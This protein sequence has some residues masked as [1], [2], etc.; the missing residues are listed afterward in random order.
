MK[1]K[2]T[3]ISLS[4]IATILAICTFNNVAAAPVNKQ[5]TNV[6][7]GYAAD[8]RGNQQTYLVAYLRNNRTAVTMAVNQSTYLYGVL[9]AGTPPTSANDTSHGIPNATINVQ[10]M[11]SDGKTWITVY[12]EKTLPDTGQTGYNYSGR[13]IMTLTPVVAGVYTYRVTYDGDSQYSPAVS[14]VVTITATNVAIS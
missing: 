10:S 9:S 4:I 6:H 1:M 14:N 13:F 5:T 7:S 11:N 2:K 12:S 3:I 8:V